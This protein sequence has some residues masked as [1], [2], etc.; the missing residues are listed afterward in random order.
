MS[1]TEISAIA[2]KIFVPATVVLIIGML[3][4]LV[5]YRFTSSRKPIPRP[6]A[7]IQTITFIKSPIFQGPAALNIDEKLSKTKLESKDKLAYSIKINPPSQNQAQILAANFGF[8]AEPKIIEDKNLGQVFQWDNPTGTLKIDNS[9][10][11]YINKPSKNNQNRTNINSKEDIMPIIDQMLERYNLQNPN[12]TPSENDVRFYKYTNGVPQ[13]IEELVDSDLIN[14]TMSFKLKDLPLVDQN[15]SSDSII[16]TIDRSGQIT[17][18]SYRFPPSIEPLNNYPLISI[19]D[20][21]TEIKSGKYTVA[22]LKP[23]FGSKGEGGDT[24]QIQ[25]ANLENVSTVYYFSQPT[26]L[27]LQPVYLFTGRSQTSLGKA[28]IRVLVPAIA[29]EFLAVP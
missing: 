21:I 11:T 29:R 10:L 1:L 13:K 17:L 27:N 5:V 6:E 12:F 24:I 2:K 23:E 26:P 28:T 25:S 4:L 3:I 18:L 20:A 22:D 14:V 9:K 7:K 16:V 8:T 15:A 19:S